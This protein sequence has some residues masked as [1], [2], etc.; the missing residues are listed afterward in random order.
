[1][2]YGA[3]KRFFRKAVDAAAKKMIADRFNE[4]IS[5]NEDLRICATSRSHLYLSKAVGLHRNEWIQ[6]YRTA[7]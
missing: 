1:M 4:A 5:K 3:A 2:P 7:I 6:A